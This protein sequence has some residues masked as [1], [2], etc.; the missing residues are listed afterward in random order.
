M[1]EEK[2]E[3]VEITVGQPGTLLVVNEPDKAEKATVAYYYDATQNPDGGTYPGVPNA[4]ILQEQFDTFPK[5]VQNSIAD[6]K[7][8]A[9][10]KTPRRTVKE[11]DVTVIT[12]PTETTPTT[13][14]TPTPTPK[15]TTTTT[16]TTTPAPKPTTTETPTQG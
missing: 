16:T 9:W 1:A 12:V 2:A 7:N 3:P 5:W 10:R 14:P 13:N 11:K 15:P 8:K 6:D 4:D